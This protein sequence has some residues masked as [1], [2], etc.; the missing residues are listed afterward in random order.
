M[1]I[2]SR[3]AGA[4]AAAFLTLTPL[5]A[6]EKPAPVSA[7]P[8][9]AVFPPEGDKPAAPEAATEPPPP[10]GIPAPPAPPPASAKAALR[11]PSEG[12]DTS[13]FDGKPV[14]RI[15]LQ[16]AIEMALTNNLEVRFERMGIASTR[17]QVRIA[18]GA[19]DPSF[20]ITGQYQRNKR[21]EDINNPST[22]Q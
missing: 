11:P 1:L 18:Q 6:Q 12:F 22:T 4:L 16:Q 2:S 21:A 17:A 5:L 14:Q 10:A 13:I 3:R 19:F 9:A 15:T 8:P 20:F 7:Y